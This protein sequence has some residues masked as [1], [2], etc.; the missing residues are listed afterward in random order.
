[1]SFT[2]APFNYELTRIRHGS[3]EETIFKRLS[4]RNTLRE[5]GEKSTQKIKM[6][7][8]N[9]NYHILTLLKNRKKKLVKPEKVTIHKVHLLII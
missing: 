8:L 9:T 4:Y 6:K 3:V 7:T 5:L 1:M 2:I